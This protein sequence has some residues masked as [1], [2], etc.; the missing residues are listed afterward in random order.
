MRIEKDNPTMSSRKKV[1]RIFKNIE[2]GVNQYRIISKNLTF[3]HYI[4][5][6]H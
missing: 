3:K 6:D 5:I 1:V 2:R 4:N